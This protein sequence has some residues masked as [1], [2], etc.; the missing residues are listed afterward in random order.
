MAVEAGVSSMEPVEVV[1]DVDG[2]QIWM[3]QV[4]GQL[5]ALVASLHANPLRHDVE[6]SPHVWEKD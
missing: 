5:G 2:W 6:M 3:V 1:L 4:S